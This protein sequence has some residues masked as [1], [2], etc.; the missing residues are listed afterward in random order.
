LLSIE[1]RKSLYLKNSQEDS[2]R[3][4]NIDIT[5]EEKS[6]ELVIPG[7]KK[8]RKKPFRINITQTNQTL[9][10]KDK[11]VPLSVIQ[12]HSWLWDLN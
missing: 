2:E 10:V 9:F 1:Y 4:N 6:F 11:L 8:T 5:Y 3:N 7:K 12:D